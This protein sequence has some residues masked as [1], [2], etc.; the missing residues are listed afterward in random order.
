MPPTCHPKPAC[1]QPG[2]LG[3]QR[4]RVWLAGVN[5][6][7]V[8][9]NGAC[10]GTHAIPVFVFDLSAYPPKPVIPTL[11]VRLA[12]CK[13]SFRCRDLLW[14]PLGVPPRLGS[15]GFTPRSSTFI[16]FYLYLI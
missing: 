15:G 9:V 3:P 13:Q 7:T 4:A 6:A 2:E 12:C 1:R 8:P 16:P 5:I 11:R 10:G 14:L